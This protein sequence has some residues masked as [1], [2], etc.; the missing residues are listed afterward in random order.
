MDSMEK[1]D[2]KLGFGRTDKDDGE[3]PIDEES[4]L[5]LVHSLVQCNTHMI[6][7]EENRYAVDPRN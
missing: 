3:E 5:Y 7:Q 6:M 2:P 4:D 1:G